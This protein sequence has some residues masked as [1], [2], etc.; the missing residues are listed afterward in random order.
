MA[1]RASKPCALGYAA[2]ATAPPSG[3][4]PQVRRRGDCAPGAL[5]VARSLRLR[6]R[7]RADCSAAWA[8]S[9][10]R[11]LRVLRP[12][13]IGR[14]PL[15]RAPRFMFRGADSGRGG[16]AAGNEGCGNIIRTEG[17]RPLPR[18]GHLGRHSPEPNPKEEGNEEGHDGDNGEP[19]THRESG[20]AG[21]ILVG[22]G[23]LKMGVGDVRGPAGQR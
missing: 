23:L 14:R 6:H 9:G 7:L 10:C 15:A 21:P 11:S 20:P 17:G 18:N 3:L 13:Y 16:F 12:V 1:E 2:C 5:G 19:C 4:P 22:L 8:P